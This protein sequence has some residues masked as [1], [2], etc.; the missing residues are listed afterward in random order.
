M[1]YNPTF[2]YPRRGGIAAVPEAFAR[3]VERLRCGARV[4]AVE[5][6]RRRV[7]L[8]GGERLGY[9]HLVVTVPLPGFLRM[10]CGVGER[11]AALAD[12]L[13]W[14]VVACLNLGVEGA[15]AGGGAHWIYFPDP[16]VPFYRAGF[17]TNFSDA[18][19]PPG[20][21]SLYV[22]FGLRRGETLD[23]D[24]AERAAL[25]ALRREGVLGPMQ[26]VI[27]PIAAPRRTRL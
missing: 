18:V 22:E 2:R 13:D 10:L 6:D 4:V 20:T 25:E 24:A 7:T 3:R 14:S 8:E 11:F 12:R 23:R 1:G 5:P 9:E 16:D 21:S 26:R 19:A 15:G 27:D 17:P